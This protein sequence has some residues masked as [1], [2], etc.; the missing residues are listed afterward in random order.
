[1]L[2]QIPDMIMFTKVS[3]L[4]SSHSLTHTHVL[5]LTLTHTLFLSLVCSLLKLLDYDPD[6]SPLIHLSCGHVFT[7]ETLDGL[8]Q[9][10]RFYKQDVKGNWEDIVRF[11]LDPS[12]PD[13]DSLAKVCCPQCRQP[14][15]RVKRYGRVI[16][17]I[18]VINSQRK[19]VIEFEGKIS[20]GYPLLLSS[21]CQFF[22]PLRSSPLFLSSSI[23]FLV[24]LFCSSPP[25]GLFFKIFSCSDLVHLKNLTPHSFT[26]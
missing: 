3:G 17:R 12:F 16:N 23:L 11:D 24:T 19:F 20:L 2:D 18:A 6:V 5:A 1:M 15:S 9:L 14:I 8:L 4:F 13:S 7:M 22:F 25:L 21:P 10:R 26:W